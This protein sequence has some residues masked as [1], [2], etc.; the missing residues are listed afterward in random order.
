M[1]FPVNPLSRRVPFYLA[2]SACILL[3]ILSAGC[4]SQAPEAAPP[5]QVTTQ[6]AVQAAVTTS[7]APPPAGTILPPANK[8]QYDDNFGKQIV[9]VSLRNTKVRSQ[10]YYYYNDVSN[11]VTLRHD[12]PGGTQLLL[13][14]VTFDLV[15]LHGS[16]SRTRFMTPLASSFALWDG[17]TFRDPVDPHTLDNPL[18]Y[19][20]KD[21]GSLYLDRW[22][23]KDNPG[24]GILV[25][26]V[27]A[28]FVVKGTYLRFCPENDPSWISRGISPRSPD[29][30]NCAEDG[31]LW[32]LG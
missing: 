11:P 6:A 20:I 10:Y 24:T 31:V 23:E 21:E 17:G 25:Y 32:R 19:Y 22:V 9:S 16:G 30:W 29:S 2:S 8:F 5:T 28:S 4:S 27:P 7:S 1:L 26:E 15:G 3:L 18:H 14:G 12:A 13:V